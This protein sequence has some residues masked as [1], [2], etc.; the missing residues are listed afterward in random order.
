MAVSGYEGT[1]ATTYGQLLVEK[2]DAKSTCDVRELAY[3]EARRLGASDAV[4]A[5]A[6]EKY[7][8]AKAVY[9][10][11]N[12]LCKKAEVDAQV[13]AIIADNATIYNAFKD[14]EAEKEKRDK[15]YIQMQEIKFLI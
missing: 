5:D 13:A 4:I 1:N 3:N 8:D 2:N 6:K 12:T 14:A 7:L 15:A 10:S 11:Y 9:D